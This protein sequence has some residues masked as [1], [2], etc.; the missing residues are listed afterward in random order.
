M[1]KLYTFCNVIPRP[2][3]LVMSC[4]KHWQALQIYR[5]QARL[6]GLQW[7]MSA[8]SRIASY[9]FVHK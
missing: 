6:I 9:V 7:S 1:E 8:T 3:R 2:D 5:G 4:Q